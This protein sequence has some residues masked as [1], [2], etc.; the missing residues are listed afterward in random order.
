MLTC[1]GTEENMRAGDLGSLVVLVLEVTTHEELHTR[2]SGTVNVAR[3][4]AR[5]NGCHVGGHGRMHAVNCGVEN[6][7]GD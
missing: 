4:R 5:N 6:G 2:E 1:F 3:L 7:E